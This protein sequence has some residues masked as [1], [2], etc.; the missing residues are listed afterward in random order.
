M[1]RH[2]LLILDL[3]AIECR[4]PH[5]YESNVCGV[6]ILD[7][8]ILLHFFCLFICVVCGS[9]ITFMDSLCHLQALLQGGRVTL[10]SGLTLAGGQKTG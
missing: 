9:S 3:P 10:A 5:F 1:T 2:L 4:P 7:R 6:I 8:E